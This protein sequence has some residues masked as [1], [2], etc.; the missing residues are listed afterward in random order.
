MS[1][2]W[3]AGDILALSNWIFMRGFSVANF[4]NGGFLPGFK[5]P[6][7]PEL[8]LKRVGRLKTTLAKKRT[9]DRP[10]PAVRRAAPGNRG[11]AGN[12]DNLMVSRKHFLYLTRAKQ[13]MNGFV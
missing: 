4:R 9:P 11:I 1:A 5:S 6:S 7:R 10:A 13:K 12:A 8:T 2:A 3:S